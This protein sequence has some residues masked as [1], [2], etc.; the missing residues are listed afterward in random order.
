MINF[1]MINFKMTTN[2]LAPFAFILILVI[3]VVTGVWLLNNAYRTTYYEPQFSNE[4]ISHSE[5]F[6]IFEAVEY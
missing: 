1:N 2:K 6:G 5:F 3:Q 4:D